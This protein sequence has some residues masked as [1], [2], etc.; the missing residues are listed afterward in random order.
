MAVATGIEAEE[1]QL[2]VVHLRDSRGK[3]GMQHW[4]MRQNPHG[5]EPMSVG[6]V[7]V[8]WTTSVAERR[9]AALAWGT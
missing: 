9:S 8:G 4:Q 3:G 2:A 7:P 5:D 6:G 1:E